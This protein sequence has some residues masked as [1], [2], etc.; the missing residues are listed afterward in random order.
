MNTNGTGGRRR[1]RPRKD[2]P[3]VEE[4]VGLSIRISP[5]LRLWLDGEAAARGETVT[6]VVERLVSLARAAAED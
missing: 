1:G 5:A 6:T 2:A 4:R 3:P